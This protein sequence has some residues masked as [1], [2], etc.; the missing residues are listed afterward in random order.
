M[1]ESAQ[2]E[3]G[4]KHLCELRFTIKLCGLTLFLNGSMEEVESRET[5]GR[6]I[7]P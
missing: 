2:S 7:C 5:Q 6:S 1:S 3:L 4:A